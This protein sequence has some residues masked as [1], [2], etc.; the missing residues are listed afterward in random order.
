MN[1][2][3]SW[4]TIACVV[5]LGACSSYGGSQPDPAVQSDLEQMKRRI[6]DLQEKA[7]MAEVE[8]ERLREQVARLEARPMVE[9]P[10]VEIAVVEPVVVDRPAVDSGWQGAN[11]PQ[12]GV[13]EESDLPLE[14][15][16]A[17]M[18]RPTEDQ[19]EINPPITGD[20]ADGSTIAPGSPDGGS[21]TMANEPVVPAAQ[22]LYDRGYTLF[23][24]GRY[25]D[26]ESSFQR[27]LQAYPRTD[28]SDNAQFWIGESRY[29]RGDI[30]GALSAFRETLQL[31]PEG[32]KTPDALVKEGDCLAGMGDRD[33]ARQSYEDVI[34]R[35]PGSAAAVMAGERIDDLQ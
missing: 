11:S 34:R 29:A 26:A 32:N 24:Q 21:G 9:E 6:L 2:G 31:Y 5:F 35:F 3:T 30:S 10:I 7:A 27:F 28:L 17:V 1:H 15:D 23:H 8:M 4:W 19:A 33:G 22:A 18:Q 16:S 14:Q 13:L 12:Q 25:L 20:A